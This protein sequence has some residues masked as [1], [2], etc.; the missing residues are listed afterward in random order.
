[1][2]GASSLNP[3][4]CLVQ[5][6]GV[7]TVSIA[8]LG[9]VPAM[10]LPPGAL[11]GGE[12]SQTNSMSRLRLL[13]VLQEPTSRPKWSLL[14]L[15]VGPDEGTLDATVTFAEAGDSGEWR[16]IKRQMRWNLKTGDLVQDREGGNEQWQGVPLEGD[17]SSAQPRPQGACEKFQIENFWVLN[18]RDRDRR[19]ALIPSG[20]YV[21][22]SA[23]VAFS[24][25]CR[26]LAA[27][28]TRGP[29]ALALDNTQCHIRI[30]ETSTGRL[31]SWFLV[32]ESGYTEWYQ[33]GVIDWST[34]GTYLIASR[35][36]ASH[37]FDADAGQSLVFQSEQ[38][39][40][41]GVYWIR[42]S[43]DLVAIQTD[44]IRI[45]SLER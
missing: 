13:Q 4:A 32:P 22:D 16:S 7:G 24:P 43:R 31:R 18:D 26:Y 25:D 34:D 44:R 21:S 27:L 15:R 28:F 5:L 41:G 11:Q 6:L 29:F 10:K 38:E 37:V 36:G 45:Y 19:N 9:C 1:M 35:P 42:N 39:M 30:W 12:L 17:P 40:S 33:K 20:S 2:N 14:W 23:R 3:A 8:L